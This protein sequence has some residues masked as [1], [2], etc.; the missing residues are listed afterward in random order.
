MSR[1]VRYLDVYRTGT[2]LHRNPFFEELL[3]C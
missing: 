3:L 2:A 1:V